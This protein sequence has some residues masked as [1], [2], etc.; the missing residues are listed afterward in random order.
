MEILLGNIDKDRFGY[1]KVGDFKT[2]SKVEAIEAHKRMGIHPHWY[3]NDHVFGSY[4]WRQEPAKS[5][6]ELYAERAWAIRKKYDHITLFYSGGADSGNILNTFVDNGIPFEEVATMNYHSLDP[7]DNTYF[8]AEQVNVS[9]P[10]IRQLQQQGIKFRHKTIDLTDIVYRILLDD[11][12]RNNLAYWSNMSFGITHLA[13]GYIRDHDPD[14]K[15]LNDQGKRHAFVWGIE[16][17]RVYIVDGR[18][19]IRFLDMIDAGPS[20]RTQLLDR[21]W[22]H[23]E[24]F[25]WDPSCC[26]LLCKQGH[27]LM[28]FFKRNKELMETNRD[29]RDDS[30]KFKIL[31]IENTF[32]KESTSDGLSYREILNWLIY[33]GFNPYT[34]S[35][36]KP[37]SIV[38]SLRDEYWLKDRNYRQSLD[39]C[40]QHL[41]SL[42]PY[43]HR[44]PGDIN[45]GLK[46]MIS[47]SYFLE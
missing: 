26:D 16:K 6:K 4:D 23:D 8:H 27:T 31:E 46:L 9:Y 36:G 7:R 11:K 39:L 22:E 14:Y 18:Y 38:Y 13:V 47:P 32:C 3:F 2:Y 34:F 17:P 29:I 19:C 41:S 15:K 40:V 5:L 28:K 33:P 24:L 1:Y 35:V 43:W 42:D 20:I 45:Q 25:Y 30:R 21:S 37:L 10:K 44:T 12:M